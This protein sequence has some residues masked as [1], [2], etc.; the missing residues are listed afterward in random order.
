MRVQVDI[1]F[2]QLL[3]IVKTLPARELQLLK[4]EIEK[5]VV[6]VKSNLDLENLL[7][8]GPTATKKQLEIIKNNR[9]AINQ[10]RTK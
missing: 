7:L 3:R 6:E 5:E 1:P 2:D 9:K 10:W 8:N 4:A